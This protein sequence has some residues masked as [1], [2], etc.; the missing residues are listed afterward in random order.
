[1][2]LSVSQ[3]E[4]VTVI[5]II[6]NPKSKWPILCQ[7]L[8]NLWVSPTCILPKNVKKERM[9]IENALGIV[10]IIV[11]ILNIV[12]GILFMNG[13][14]NDYIMMWN[15][16]FWLGSVFLI[17]GVMTIL[18]YCIGSYVVLFLTVILNEANGLMALIGVSMYSWDFV[19]TRSYS[20]YDYLPALTPEQRMESLLYIKDWIAM[21]R[22]ALDI[23]MIVFTILQF[24]ANITFVVM[25]V[26][27]Y[28][29]NDDDPQLHKLLPEENTGKC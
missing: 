14:I 27:A 18:E 24:C 29:L 28:V 23:V 2:S 10:Q 5:T 9:S 21:T 16:P 13:G 20:A 8:G 12:A 15:T 22:G 1:M 26:K 11:G 7:I 19:G 4:G 17:S 6:S 3:D 25:S